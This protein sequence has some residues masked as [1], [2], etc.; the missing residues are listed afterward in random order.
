MR[1]FAI[2]L[3]ICVVTAAAWPRIAY[4][5]AQGAVAIP[6]WSPIPRVS[7]L[8]PRPR[9]K[10]CAQPQLGM[11]A[12]STCRLTKEVLEHQTSVLTEQV[13]VDLDADAASR[14]NAHDPSD[15]SDFISRQRDEQSD[16]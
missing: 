8:T 14:M 2:L 15:D 7:N 3:A 1:W 9:L 4:D 16:L 13:Q 12:V 10:T 11:K 5:S 6:G